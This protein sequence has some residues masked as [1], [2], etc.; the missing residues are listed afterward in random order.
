[1]DRDLTG[2]REEWEWWDGSVKEGCFICDAIGH[3]RDEW[4]R[5]GI[6]PITNAR[7]VN[8]FNSIA[9]KV[10]DGVMKLK[11]AP[12]FYND[13]RDCMAELECPYRLE[14]IGVATLRAIEKLMAPKRDLP[15][16]AD[17]ARDI[18]KQKYQCASCSTFLGENVACEVDH[19]PRI[20]E[21]HDTRIQILCVSCHRTKSSEE[22]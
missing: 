22:L 5:E 16:E 12:Q 18:I 21:A 15:T 2:K 1:M 9:R 20:S 7:G 19:L 4:L 6:V 8:K 13:R 10:G 14:S 3:V 11:A 17:K